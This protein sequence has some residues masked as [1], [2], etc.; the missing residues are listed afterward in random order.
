MTNASAIAVDPA[1]LEAAVDRILGKPFRMLARGPGEFYCLGLWLYL[2]EEAQG[3]W[4]EDPFIRPTLDSITSFWRRFL[5]V[6]FEKVRPLDAFYHHNA[7]GVTSHVSVIE[8]TRWAVD[9]TP[10]GVV[11]TPYHEARA[12]AEKAYRV[13][14]EVQ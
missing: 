12:R 13:R 4:I 6:P 1:R 5:P 14:M 8:S 10:L 7:D 3:I 2:L 11:R 9:V